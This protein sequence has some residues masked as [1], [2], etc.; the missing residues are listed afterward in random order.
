MI[1]KNPITANWL[2]CWTVVPLGCSAGPEAQGQQVL[3]LG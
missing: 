2:W 3:Q 1:N